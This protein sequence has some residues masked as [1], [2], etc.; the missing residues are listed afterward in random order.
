EA[1]AAASWFGPSGVTT[2]GFASVVPQDRSEARRNHEEIVGVLWKLRL[3]PLL[4]SDPM[5]VSVGHRLG[6]F[7][8]LAQL[9]SGGLGDFHR[10]RDSRLR[11]VFP[12]W[13]LRAA[14]ER[15]IK[16]LPSAFSGNPDRAGRFAHEAR[17]ATSL[18][19]PNIVAVHDV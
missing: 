12:T 5:I 18:N 7:E 15:A 6:R 19:H 10:P 3:R 14:P 13:H 17:A 2:P 9:G 8:V 11:P 4:Y 16:L 1:V